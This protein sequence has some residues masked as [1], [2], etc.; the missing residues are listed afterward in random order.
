MSA[1]S[2]S[3]GSWLAF[4][5]CGRRKRVG[6]A[7]DVAVFLL[8]G[9]PGRFIVADYIIFAVEDG[10]GFDILCASLDE[11]ILG[12]FVSVMMMM[13]MIGLDVPS[14]L[15]SQHRKTYVSL[16]AG[17]LSMIRHTVLFSLRH[18]LTRRTFE[19]R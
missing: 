7:Y 3:K 14:I 17:M 10:D 18:T 8:S 19:Y 4:C 2:G 1:G 15:Q 11:S 5:V 9:C 6:A 12:G 13:M 16:G